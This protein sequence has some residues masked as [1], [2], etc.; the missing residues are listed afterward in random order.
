MIGGPTARAGAGPAIA[1]LVGL[2]WLA[3]ADAATP[4]ARR[5]PAP[6][7]ILIDG[8]DLFLQVVVAEGD[9]AATLGRTYLEDP[10]L[11]PAVQG[12]QAHSLPPPG[13][14]IR[15]PYE[16]LHPDWV[17]RVARDLF[18]A[19]RPG[20]GYW[21]H[22]VGAGRLTVTEESLWNLSLWF[23]GRGEN[24]EAIADRNGLHDLAPRP[25][26][27]LIVPG[28]LLLPPF[29]GLAGLSPSDP[30]L[31][32]DFS[33][34]ATLRAPAARPDTGETAP[35]EPPAPPPD[36]TGAT[37]DAEPQ[38][39]A[40]KPEGTPPSSSPA[41]VS[42]EGSDELRYG[43]DADG[44][45]AIYRLKRGEAIY[46]AVVV[47]FTGRLDAADVNELA[48]DIIRRSRIADVKDIAVG[49]PIKIPLDH[50]LPEYLPPGD[51]RRVAWEKSEAGVARYT[52]PVR[53]RDLEGVAVILDAGHGGRDQGA[54]HNGVWE[55]DYVYDILCRIKLLLERETRARV[56]T[57]IRDREEGYAI[58]TKTKVRRSQA[59]VLLT[60]PPYPL[61]PGTMSVNLR[62]YLANSHHRA[63]VEEGFDP[64]KIVFTSL[65]ADARHP[66]L[67]G[68]MVYV[69]GEEYR[70]GRYGN[71]GARYAKYGEV[72]QAPFV[73][74][75]RPERER[76]EAL[77]REF[78]T[79]FIKALQ[80][81]EIPVYSHSPIRER[82]I[83]RGRSWVP[84]VLRCNIVPVEVLIEI[85]NLS[86][87]KD[88]HRLAKP[89]FRQKV[90]EAYVEALRNYYD[91]AAAPL[92][93]GIAAGR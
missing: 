35:P 77:S 31:D 18:P 62:W 67:S 40:G 23:T 68:A 90:A 21:V 8:R 2:L 73:S 53:S 55:H 70:R 22:Q 82:I 56:L 13:G 50:L 64:L 33:S 46:S 43:S 7:A 39:P 27:Q 3:A 1:G 20:D 37:G 80:G 11:F 71:G 54:A 25:G 44:P 38:P 88:S 12:L 60:E 28:D 26:Q 81:A 93:A 51:P 49:H 52:N 57:T 41:P 61:Q 84:A 17:V 6:R 87:N 4:G 89:S 75:S 92:T 65:H 85:C 47:R 78:A 48:A 79:S 69:P 63:L 86:N 34:I 5:D 10:R 74:F 45:Y 83:R 36:A 76:S 14:I 42:A 59:E 72:R 32:D 58:R 19:D 29:A 16:L 24:F 66:S 30:S 91:G 15:I 9:S